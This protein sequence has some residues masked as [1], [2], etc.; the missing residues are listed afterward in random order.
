MHLDVHLPSPIDSLDWPFFGKQMRPENN[1]SILCK[2]DD[3]IHPL[4]SGNKWR[5]LS[6]T[7]SRLQKANCRHIISFGGAYSNHL[8]ALSYAC[9]RINIQLTAIIRGNYERA[10]TPTLHDMTS[11]GTKLQFVSKIEYKK[12]TE[13]AYCKNI[14]AQF[15]ADYLIPE[16]GSSIDCLHG[17]AKVIEEC[18]IQAP[19]ITHI[20]LP[21]ASGG[22]LA[23]LITS[24]HLPD[25]KLIG[26]GVL[27]GEGYLETLVEN[28]IAHECSPK[29]K[30]KAWQILHNFHH[31]GYAKTS[32]ELALFVAQFNQQFACSAQAN[33]M[34]IE[35]VYSGKCFYALDQLLSANFF[36]ENSKV[37]IIHTGGIQGARQAI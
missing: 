30:L 9:M 22:T 28:L 18:H 37:L 23:G 6:A 33:K 3:L 26:I 15:N 34:V 10:L 27:K 25:V 7:L 4:V 20:V 17:V 21:V 35:P 29:A 11:W 32:K 8:H 14:I 2:R 31:G 1:V 12:R 24:K 5:K 36:P 13:D 16:G 19:D